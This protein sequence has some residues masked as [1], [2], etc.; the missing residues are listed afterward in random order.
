MKFIVAFLV[1]SD[2]LAADS[3]WPELSYW[4][5]KNKGYISEKVEM[6]RGEFGRG[7]FAKQDLAKGETLFKIQRQDTISARYVIQVY[8]IRVL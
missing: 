5:R 7:M 4:F 6:G 2:V 8:I 3:S 1:V